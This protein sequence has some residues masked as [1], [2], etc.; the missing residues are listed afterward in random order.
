[1]PILLTAEVLIDGRGAVHRPGALLVDGDR[2][3]AVGDRVDTPPGTEHV[4]FEGATILP[5]LVDCHVHLSDAGL[6]DA[7]VQDRDPPALRSLRIAEHARRTLVAGF[8]TVRDVGGRDH[9]E[10]GFRRAVAEGLARAPR[11]VLAGKVISITTAGA[12][13]WRGMYRQADGP[14]EIAK[15]VREQIAARADVIKLMATGAVLSPGHERPGAAQLT[16]DELRAAVGTAHA[17]GRRVA[18]H[19][20]GIEGIRNAVEAGVDTIEHG[21]HL[22]EDPAV[23]RAMA[24]RG[25]FLVPTLKALAGI[26]DGRRVPAEIAAKARDRRADRD[27]TFRLALAEGVPIAMGTDAATPFNRHGENAQELAIMVELG[28]DPM[29]AIVAT[30]GAGARAI[31]REDVGVLAAG[32]LAD[33][34][35][36]QGDPLAGVRVLER[37]PLAVFLGGTRIV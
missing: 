3:V 35:V 16:P 11:L 19:A 31:G 10:F 15:A 27:T 29:A 21:T 33:V 32:R 6:P 18:A 17:L 9:L 28:M 4:H 5:G 14:P 24:E 37:P 7:T 34:A 8:T 23:A 26:A 20:H 25:I 30:T 12:S 22:H 2:I 36:W 13:A 1:V